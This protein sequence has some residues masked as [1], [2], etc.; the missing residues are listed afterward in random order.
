MLLIAALTLAS[1][2]Q[3]DD[4]AGDQR[5][6][7]LISYRTDC[8]TMAAA[9]PEFSKTLNVKLEVAKD[10]EDDLLILR[11]VDTPAKETL[12]VIAD[13]FGWQWKKTDDGYQLY[14]SA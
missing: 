6:T 14:R 12:N 7:Q 11:C 2:L 1:G 3:S 4:F 13:H 9:L 8:S 5:L 10:I